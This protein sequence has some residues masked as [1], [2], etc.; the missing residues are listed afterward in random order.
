MFGLSERT[1]ILAANGDTQ[2]ELLGFTAPELIVWERGNERR[3]YG[4]S[5]SDH[6]RVWGETADV[7]S[8]ARANGYEFHETAN[9]KRDFARTLAAIEDLQ[10]PFGESAFAADVLSL[11][12]G[13]RRFRRGAVA[14]KDLRHRLG[15]IKLRKTREDIARMRTAALKS[16]EAHRELLT[17]NWIGRREIDVAMKFDLE[18]R[19]RGI[20]KTA[21]ESIVGAGDRAMTLHARASDRVIGDGELILVDAAGMW[22]G[23]CADITRTF[24]SGKSFTSSQRKLYDIVLKAQLAA[25]AA[26]KP[27]ATLDGIHAL[28]R[29]TLKEGLLR[30][31]WLAEDRDDLLDLWFPHKTSHWLGKQVHDRA[32]YFEDDGSPLRLEEGMVLTVE[33]GLYM[34]GEEASAEIRGAGIRIEDDVVVTREGCEVLSASAPK[35]ADE[36]EADRNKA[37][38]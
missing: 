9:F 4:R 1:L 31:K 22:D 24:P 34:R 14:L 16:G 19:R 37:V 30:E 6:D 12:S 23:F 8:Y 7:E 29:E 28:A 17:E 20:D 27:G 38:V 5:L 10:I 13:D 3:L 25:I 2:R 11:L 15:E 35:D 36:I 26:V 18:L 32:P 33:P 21:Y